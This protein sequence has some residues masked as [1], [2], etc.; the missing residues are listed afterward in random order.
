MKHL[1]QATLLSLLVPG[2]LPAQAPPPKPIAKHAVDQG[3]HWLFLQGAAPMAKSATPVLDAARYLV[4]SARCHRAYTLEDGPVVRPFLDLVFKNRRPEGGFYGEDAPDPALSTRW[5]VEAFLYLDPDRYAPEIETARNFLKSR[6]K[7]DSPRTL[8]FEALVGSYARQLTALPAGKR[9]GLM[10]QW[11]LG[12][13]RGQDPKGFWSGE[14]G[15]LETT[16]DRVVRL[17][18]LEQFLFGKRTLPSAGV[19]PPFVERGIDFLVSRAKDGKWLLAGAP[20]PGITALCLTAVLMRPPAKRTEKDKETIEKAIQYLLSVQQSDGSFSAGGTPVYVTS[21][22]IEAFLAADRPELKPAVRKGMAYLLFMQNIEKRGYTPGDR[23]YGSIG[24]GD[25]NRGDLS[26]LQMALDALRSAGLPKSDESLVKAITFLQRTQNLASRN[27]YRGTVVQEGKKVPVQ[28][29]NDGGAAYY[30]GYSNAGFIKLA[31]GTLVPRSYGSMTW[32]LLKSYILCGLTKDDER[33]QAAWNW[34]RA[35]YTLDYN[36]GFPENEPNK[37]YQGLFYYYLTMARTLAI[38]GVDKVMVPVK[39]KTGKTTVVAH[40]WRAE[41]L[42]KLKQL[43]KPDGSW[44]ND[45]ASRWME[46]NPD[47]A[48]AYAVLIAANCLKVPNLPLP[49]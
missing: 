3:L 29:G 34:L 9:Q 22:A 10:L 26:N 8:P 6:E 42:A 14:K 44:V 41:M 12:L 23:D 1:L 16:L 2:L 43:Q 46:G 21:A 32:A 47:L 38:M 25:D 7:K 48:T 17:V 19:L 45:K 39:D 18:A 28:P 37:H 40:D 13:V 5:A 30:P 31:D 35:H 20:H 4:A 24:Y 33:V 15:K 11:V 49:K 36:P 27:D